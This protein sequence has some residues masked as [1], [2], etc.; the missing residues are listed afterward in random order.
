MTAMA[1]PE[2]GFTIDPSTDNVIKGEKGTQIFIP[3]NALRFPDG[4]APTG[5]VNVELKEFFSISD[6][7]SNSLSTTS[8]SF[9]LETA[10][11]L[12]V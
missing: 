11:M 10:G 3:A 4:T 2:Q 1:P 7:V 5:K 12:Y 6:F 8:D 9:L